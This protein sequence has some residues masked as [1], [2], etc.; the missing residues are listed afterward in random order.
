MQRTADQY[1]DVVRLGFG[2]GRRRLIVHL[3]R[4][5]DAFQHV[6]LTNPANYQRATNYRTLEAL[7]GKGLLTNEGESW[8]RQRRLIQPSFARRQARRG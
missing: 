1:G 3:L 7:L 5:P 6:L 8:T 2:V 4:T